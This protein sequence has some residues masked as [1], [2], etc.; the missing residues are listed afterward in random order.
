MRVRHLKLLYAL[1]GLLL[2]GYW[3]VELLAR[4]IADRVPISS[5]TLLCL[6]LFV[7]IPALG[8]VFLFSLVPYLLSLNKKH[9]PA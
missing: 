1:I 4:H 8:Y 9:R 5:G 2:A 7:A 6:L 3:S